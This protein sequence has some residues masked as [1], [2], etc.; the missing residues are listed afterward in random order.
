ML[1]ISPGWRVKEHID[2]HTTLN[3]LL[4]I[5]IETYGSPSHK[6]ILMPG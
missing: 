4:V 6:G 2:A 1:G 3:G 5:L